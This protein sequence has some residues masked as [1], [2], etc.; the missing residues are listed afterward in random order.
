MA[1]EPCQA[2]YVIRNETDKTDINTLSIAVKG[3]YSKEYSLKSAKLK[4]RKVR[5]KE[6][7]KYK[8]T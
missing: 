5:C 1:D 4:I 3:L 8:A 7:R 6:F 2:S